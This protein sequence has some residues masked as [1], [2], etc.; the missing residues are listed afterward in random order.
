MCGAYAKEAEWY[1]TGYTPT[2]EEYIEVSWISISAHT[3]LSYVF[4]L[5]TNPIEDEAAESLRNYHNV[6]RCSAMVLRLADD[7]GTSQ[8][9]TP[10]VPTNIR[11]FSMKYEII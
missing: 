8:V 7:L 4:F 6:I 10:S 2:L 11:H 3:I 1:Y 5:I 9:S